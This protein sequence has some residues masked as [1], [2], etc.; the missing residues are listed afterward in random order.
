MNSFLPLFSFLLRS[1]IALVALDKGGTIY[2]YDLDSTLD[3]PSVFEDYIKET[4][5]PLKL[6]EKKIQRKFQR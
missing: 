2:V 4:F 6:Y 1:V 3:F 5:E